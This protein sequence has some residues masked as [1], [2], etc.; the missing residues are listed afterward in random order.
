MRSGLLPQLQIGG[1]EEGLQHQHRWL[2]A[3]RGAAGDELQ[4]LFD[5][6]PGFNG[7]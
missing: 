1:N 2:A 4:A 5:Y 6:E 3:L 7:L